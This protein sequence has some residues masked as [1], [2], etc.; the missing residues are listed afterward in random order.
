M[1]NIKFLD[2]KACL[3]GHF[4]SVITIVKIV[5]F[6]M[7]NQ[8]FFKLQFFPY[9]TSFKIIEKNFLG[10]IANLL[11]NPS[12]ESGQSFGIVVS[13]RDSQGH[14]IHASKSGDLCNFGET[15]AVCCTL[16]LKKIA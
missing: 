12:I 9:D 5:D 10:K 1:E 16:S 11:Q 14:S 7:K 15:T 8:T 3:C 13:I 6:C 2:N 4:T